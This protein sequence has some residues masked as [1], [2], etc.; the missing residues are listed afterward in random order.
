MS[1]DHAS[2]NLHLA[3]LFTVREIVLTKFNWLISAV[4]WS[5]KM[6]GESSKQTQKPFPIK[7]RINTKQFIAWKVALLCKKLPHMCC[8]VDAN[9][10]K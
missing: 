8:T 6:S 9:E 4:V 7:K 5:N 1:A 3:Y 10:S 2:P